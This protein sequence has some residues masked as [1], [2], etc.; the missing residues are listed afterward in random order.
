V[1]VVN[2]ALILVAIPLTSI[3]FFTP[4][5]GVHARMVQL[6]KALEDQYAKQAAGLEEQIKANLDDPEGLIDAKQ[7]A[8]E[9]K[10]LRALMPND[11]AYPEWPFDRSMPVKL[12]ASPVLSLALQFLVDLFSRPNCCG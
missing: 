6:K 12:F 8:E 9:L 5:S 4:V 2:A 11:F 1:P 7:A 3:S 10:V